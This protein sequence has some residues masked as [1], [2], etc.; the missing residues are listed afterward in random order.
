MIH[1][2]D[3]LAAK[4][5]VVDDLEANVLLLERMLHAAGYTSVESTT[6]PRMVSELHGRNHY[7]L[8]VLDLQMPGMDGFEV[9]ENLKVVQPD[10]YLP[11]IV[12]TA[13]PDHKLRALQAGAKDFVSKPFDLGEVLMRVRNMLEVRLLHSESLQ[14]G[15]ELER[16]VQEL[17]AS[18]ETIV[19]QS[20]ELRRLYEKL[21]CEQQVTERLLLNVLPA[22]IAE[23]LKQRSHPLSAGPPDVIADRFES[24][25]VL[26]AD[27]VHFT[28]FAPG[29]SPELL[30]E[31]LNEIFAAFDEIADGRGLEKIKTIGDAY[32]AAAGLPIPVADHAVRAAHMALDMMESLSRFNQRSG[33]AL[34]LRIGIHSGAVVAGVIGRRKF[35]YDLWGDTVNI[36][37]R[38]ESQGIV[39]G[40]QVTDDTRQQL[41][42]TFLLEDHGVIAARGIGDV[43]TW[44]LVGRN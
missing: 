20:D 27:I 40:I 39:G 30:V 42:K 22:P 10:S 5:L 2:S 7:D 43:H 6:D 13:Q 44:H 15:K 3:I 24:V 23:R 33:Y 9:M 8:I 11:V 38:M 28:R 41:G 14:Y 4:I 37:S 17:E 25:S 34:R 31:V 21:V 1:P 32:M 19:R 29:M 36:A 12:V 35:I 26:F 16:K 18:R